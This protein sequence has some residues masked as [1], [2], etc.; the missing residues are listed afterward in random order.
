M[1]SVLR[2][3]EYPM[4]QMELMICCGMAS[5]RVGMLVVSAGKMETVT[6]TDTGRQ[7]L[8]CF[9]YSVCEINSR[10]FF[11]NRRFIFVGL[12]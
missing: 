4:P 7:N 5:K 10:T 1:K 9:V 11:L 3:A 8:T 2:S 12:S 6:L